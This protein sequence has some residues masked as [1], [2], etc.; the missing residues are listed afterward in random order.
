MPSISVHEIIPVWYQIPEG[1][2]RIAERNAAVHTTRC[3]HSKLVRRASYVN[4][5]MVLDA[6]VDRPLERGLPGDL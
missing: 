6:L 1:A 5:Q 4:L 2:A 3:L